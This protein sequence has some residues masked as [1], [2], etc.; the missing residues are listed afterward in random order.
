MTK[1]RLGSDR[2]KGASINTGTDTKNT[3]AANTN[4]IWLIAIAVGRE[5]DKERVDSNSWIPL[6]LVSA[7]YKSVSIEEFAV[8]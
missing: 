2:T 1:L 6:G 8:V 7:V 5:G 4:Q 3:A